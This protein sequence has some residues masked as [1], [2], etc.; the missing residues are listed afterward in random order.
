[1]TEVTPEHSMCGEDF[2]ADLHPPTG[3]PAVPTTT[4]S[5][6]DFKEDI[7]LPPAEAPTARH[8]VAQRNAL[9]NWVSNT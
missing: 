6:I 4:S 7:R 8:I 3:P 1:M 9:G 5:A 2:K